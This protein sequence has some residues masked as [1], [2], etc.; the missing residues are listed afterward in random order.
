LWFLAAIGIAWEV[1]S[2]LF[3]NF[4]S[5][6]QLPPFAFFISFYCIFIFQK[7][8]REEQLYSLKWNSSHQIEAI[9][10]A[11]H[12][13]SN[14]D[15]R[16]EFFGAIIP[17]FIN[18]KPI[19]YYNRSF[20]FGK[21]RCFFGLFLSLAIFL[22]CVLGVLVSFAGIY[23]GRYQ[24]RKHYQGDLGG[25]VQY[26]ASGGT[27]LVIIVYCSIFKYVN[28]MITEFENHRTNQNY[29]LSLTG[30]RGFTFSFVVKLS[31]SFLSFLSFVPLV[32]IRCLCL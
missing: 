26:I 10:K 18:G 8:K 29:Y 22:V 13:T 6:A 11:N 23:Y 1:L 24:L 30:E 27:G 19:V 16:P 7:W 2:I 12:H 3:N 28:Y 25:Y 4:N 20:F 31:L 5:L 14:N 21:I 15:I 17:S 32:V 9:N